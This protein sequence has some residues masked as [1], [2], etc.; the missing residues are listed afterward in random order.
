[1]TPR[2][3]SPQVPLFQP[4][5]RE[6]RNRIVDALEPVLYCGGDYVIREGER[7]EHFYLIEAGAVRV[8]STAQGE[9]ATRSAGDYFG[10]R[11]LQTGEP[12][13]ASVTA[14]GVTR[15]VRMARDAF[16]RILGPLAHAISSPSASSAG[17]AD[18]RE[19]ATACAGGC[20]DHAATDVPAAASDARTLDLRRYDSSTG[21]EIC[22]GNVD[23]SATSPTL[24]VHASGTRSPPPSPPLLDLRRKPPVTTPRA[25]EPPHAA[26]P[27]S[28]TSFGLA[29]FLVSPEPIGEGGFGKVRL[30]QHAATGERY[31]LKQMSKAHLIRQNQAEHAAD[32]SRV[33]EGLACPFIAR[34]FGSFQTAGHLFLVL[35]LAPGGDVYD[36]LEA[37][38][39]TIGAE[40]A[41]AFVAQLLVALEH[42]HARSVV[43]R[44][45]KL[46]NLLLAA[47]GTLKLTD[48][49]F[50]KA[51]EY[52]TFTLCGTPEY[53]APE[54]ILNKGY[55]RGVDYWA[56]GI[57]LYEM[58]AG[59]AQ[60][61]RVRRDGE[62]PR[63]AHSRAHAALL[64]HARW[65][66]SIA[67]HRANPRA[68]SRRSRQRT[69][70]A[71]TR[72]SCT[73][74]SSSLAALR[75]RRPT[76]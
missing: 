1:M 55:G 66:R 65:C 29:S 59:C 37:N 25:S 39:G 62:P 27:P 11:A 6:E 45:V 3:V 7:G 32:E 16:I 61:T 18:G 35:E 28:P 57:V 26:P 38:G 60:P 72:T 20:T 36:L 52:R 63:S 68:A 43:H 4:L 23:K 49:G 69:I 9:L 73:A 14:V 15:L 50:A 56:L 40:D 12:T 58:L 46:E 10:E 24:G 67:T 8:S 31:A 48:F 13:I 76:W 64:T 75:R 34:K 41:R 33:L 53:L 54:V 2:P 19:P 70:S 47:D 5:T 74:A 30:A 51:V 71:R 44:D 42:L 17:D 21:K 22:T